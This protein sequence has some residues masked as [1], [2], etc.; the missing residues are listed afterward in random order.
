MD[1]FLTEEQ[2]MLCDSVRRFSDEAVAPAA[3]AI[4]RDDVFPRE[5]YT[6]MADLG[7]FGVSLDH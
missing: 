2:Q 1:R 3:S 4:D 5:L 7:L 6:A